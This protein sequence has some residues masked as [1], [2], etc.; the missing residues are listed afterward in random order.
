MSLSITALYAGGLGLVFLALSANV[1]RVRRADNV[2]L[3]HEGNLRLERAVR[4]HAN[5]SEYVP[6]ILLL[7]G[8]AEL[9]D[10]PAWRLHLLGGVLLTGRLLHAYCFALTKGHFPTRFAGMAL[11]F[12]ALVAGS[13]ECL[14]AAV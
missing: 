8:V 5:F 10:T 9:S 4:G 6:F 14:R 13:V 12:A 2:S 1:I 11:T 7:M 3:G